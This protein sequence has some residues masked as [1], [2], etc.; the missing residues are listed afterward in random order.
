MRVEKWREDA[1]PE[2]PEGVPAF[3]NTEDEDLRGTRVLPLGEMPAAADVRGADSGPGPLEGRRA[4]SG[5]LPGDGD[6]TQVLPDAAHRAAPSARPEPRTGLRAGDTRGPAAPGRTA[7]SEGRPDGGW[8]TERT[9]VL[10][11]PRRPDGATGAKTAGPPS[12]PDG[13]HP[14]G[15]FGAAGSPSALR[16]PSS[17]SGTAGAPTELLRPAPDSGAPTELLPPT[18]DSGAPAVSR[19]PVRDPWQEEAGD[20]AAAAHDPHEVTVQLD[21]VQIGEGLELRRTTSRAG[22]GR[23]AAGGP[24]FVDESGRR[25]RLYRR[26]GLAVGLA[27]VGYAVVMVATLLSGNSDAPWMPVPGQK[28]EPAGQVE[29]TPR[30]GE[31]GATPGSGT[32]IVPGGAPTTGAPTLPVSATTAP[33]TG[34]GAGASDQP[35]AADPTPEP[36]RQNTTAPA[37]GG[38]DTTTPSDD[39][40]VSTAPADPS[41]SEIPDPVPTSP[42]GNGKNKGNGGGKAV[43]ASA[44]RTDPSTAPTASS[45]ENVI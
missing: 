16:H 19:T 30:P 11:V 12:R 5:F 31:T 32:G 7:P 10:R 4:H 45:P 37:T 39:T 25:I 15:D 6:R 26:I 1:Q 9:T 3:G 24:V 28:G 36:T 38:S 23:Q 33:A 14:S 27:C 43:G 21:S 17:A 18:P 2:R 20:S 44:A 29:T 35:D 42:N 22:G 40:T 41:V 13:A 34:G 8:D